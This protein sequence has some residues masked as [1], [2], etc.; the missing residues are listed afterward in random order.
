MGIDKIKAVHSDDISKF[1]ESLEILD[2]VKNGKYKCS[3]CNKE[4]TLFNIACI[5]P[6]GKEV[7]FCCDNL[8]CYEA[9]VKRR[10]GENG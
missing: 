6:D 7:K 2:D 5:Y 8:T 3:I 9:I 10:P 1:L 4:I